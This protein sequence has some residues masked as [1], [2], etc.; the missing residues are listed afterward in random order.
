M[1][2]SSNSRISINGGS[3]W[4][5]WRKFLN[6]WNTSKCWTAFVCMFF[7]WCHS[8]YDSDAASHIKWS[9]CT[10]GQRRSIGSPPGK[11]ASEL[12]SP[13]CERSAWSEPRWPP[14]TGASARTSAQEAR[15]KGIWGLWSFQEGP[16]G[17]RVTFTMVLL[18]RIKVWKPNHRSFMQS[19]NATMT[20]ASSSR[21]AWTYGGIKHSISCSNLHAHA[22]APVCVSTHVDIQPQRGNG[23]GFAERQHHEEETGQQLHHVEEVVVSEQVSCQGLCIPGVSEELIIVLPLLFVNT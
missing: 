18:C 16:R 2:K 13:A 17:V 12:W 7:S 20:K 6:E 10:C 3:D 14:R 4:K 19:S 5:I 23:G 21:V 8:E 9:L 15:Q 11:W 22:C 1:K